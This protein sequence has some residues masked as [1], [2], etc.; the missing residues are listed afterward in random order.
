M[1]YVFGIFMSWKE[2]SRVPYTGVH[3]SSYKQ[4]FNAFLML[5]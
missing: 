1:Q 4:L 5:S 3:I 2:L